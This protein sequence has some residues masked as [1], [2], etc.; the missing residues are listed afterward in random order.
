MAAFI[1]TGVLGGIY[2]IGTPCVYNPS[3]NEYQECHHMADGQ[4][5]HYGTSCK[6]DDSCLY[7]PDSEEFRECNR[8]SLGE[9]KDFSAMTCSPKENC[10]YNPS[11]EKYQKCHH[12]SGGECHHYGSTCE[13]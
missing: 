2:S 10:I 3:D 12:V 11:T 6:P 9:C 8:F 4:C 1:I 13:P 7:D 5:Q